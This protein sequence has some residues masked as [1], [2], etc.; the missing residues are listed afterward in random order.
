MPGRTNYWELYLLYVLAK[1]VKTQNILVE[2]S[3]DY[4]TWILV[5]DR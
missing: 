1:V 3:S 4:L 5:S 2:K